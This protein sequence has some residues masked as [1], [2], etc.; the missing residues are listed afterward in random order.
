MERPP[1]QAFSSQSDPNLALQDRYIGMEIKGEGDR[2]YRVSQVIGKG[3]MGKIYKAFDIYS[4]EQVAVKFLLSQDNPVGDN[5]KARFLREAEALSRVHHKNVVEIRCVK[6]LEDRIDNGKKVDGEI[7]VVMELLEGRD[8]DVMLKEW[9]KNNEIC[10]W[11]DAKP[12]LLQI[13]EALEAVHMQGILHRDLKPSNIMIMKR[14]NDLVVKLLDFGLAKFTSKEDDDG[15][16][17]RTMMFLGTPKYASPEQA[18]G[19]K[20]KTHEEEGYDHRVD[21]YALGV[22]MYHML[23]GH[24]PFQGATDMDVL[25]NIIHMKPLRPSIRNPRANVPPEVEKIIMKAL[26]KDP[27]KRFQTMADMMDA[28]KNDGRTDSVSDFRFGDALGTRGLRLPRVSDRDSEGGE[29]AGLGIDIRQ[30]R[31]SEPQRKKSGWG[32]AIVTIGVLAGL[33]GAG[34]H[35]RDYLQERWQQLYAIG[36][37]KI[38]SIDLGEGADARAEKSR[39]YHVSVDSDPPGAIV[40]VQEKIGTRT[41][42]RRLGRTGKGFSSILPP[43][44]HTLVISK[45]RRSVTVEVSETNNAINVNL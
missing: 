22:I 18:R 29:Y 25:A 17:T 31:Q 45:G 38:Q 6:G 39:P 33:A 24:V 23:C 20:A 15:H 3:G 11:K 4:N 27:D 14:E 2:I 42:E 12:I 34:Y 5:V 19:E 32:R 37:E 30:I 7:Y 9:E 41:V 10:S 36:K 8:L 35:Y 28:I 44:T 26:E 21:I 43:G 1:A 40:S 13:C 16:Q